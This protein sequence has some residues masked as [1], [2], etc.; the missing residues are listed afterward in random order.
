MEEWNDA[1]I[2][3]QC[4]HYGEVSKDHSPVDELRSTGGKHLLFNLEPEDASILPGMA[5]NIDS[6]RHLLQIR[7]MSSCESCSLNVIR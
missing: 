6:A 4:I 2:L 1:R 5:S 3:P 7:T